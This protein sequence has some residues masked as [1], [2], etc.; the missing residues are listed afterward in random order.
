MSRVAVVGA[1]TMGN[2]IAH[3]FAQHG[4]D[5]TLIDVA[6]GLLERALQLV[7]A[8]FDRQ[9]KKGTVTVDQRDAALAHTHASINIY[10][11]P[12][13]L[14]PARTASPWSNPPRTI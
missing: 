2:G 8:A 13:R 4:W 7:R 3:V 5:T 1:G 6:P 12:D 14:A 11:E 9:V 10:P